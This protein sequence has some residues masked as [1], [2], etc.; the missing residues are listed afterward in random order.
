M[1]QPVTRLDRNGKLVRKPVAMTMVSN[2]S[3]VPSVKW[4]V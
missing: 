3:C 2:A 1:S 4:T